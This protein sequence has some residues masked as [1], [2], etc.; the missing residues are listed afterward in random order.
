MQES[1]GTKETVED[2]ELELQQFE[3]TVQE[4]LIWRMIKLEG[5]T[6][7]LGIGAK[8]IKLSRSSLKVLYGYI[9]SI[10]DMYENM[11]SDVPTV[12]IQTKSG[13]Y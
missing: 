12:Y 8:Y 11:Y 4:A 2:N 3:E 13:P 6:C 5:G 9:R 10:L 1:L 7:D